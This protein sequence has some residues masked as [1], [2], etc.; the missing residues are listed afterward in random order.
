M[1]VICE[2]KLSG[3]CYTLGED[4]HH[5]RR[6]R[7]LVDMPRGGCDCTEPSLCPERKRLVRCVVVEGK[8]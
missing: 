7:V 6:H 5:A 4:C 3:H 1:A 8:E 2:A